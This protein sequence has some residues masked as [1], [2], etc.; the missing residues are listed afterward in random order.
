MAIKNVL[1][2]VTVLTQTGSSS[3]KTQQVANTA[4][5]KIV[6]LHT[7]TDDGAGAFL[8]GLG[9]VNYV[10]KNL[11]VKVVSADRTTESYN[12]DY[13][14]AA[15]F[16][17][18]LG[19]G[20]GNGSSTGIKGGSYG[21]ASVGEEILAA[22][23][24]VAKYRV[25]PAVVQDKSYTFAPEA[26]VIDLCPL[27]SEPIA[28]GS[29]MFEWMG[30]VYQDFE[31][32][33]YRGRTNSDPGIDSGALDYEGGKAMMT[34]YVVGPNPQTINILALWT[35]KGSWK[36]SSSF[37]RTQAAPVKPSSAIINL[38][39]TRG[40]AITVQGD[41]DGNLVGPHS[42]GS[43]DYLSGCGQLLF[44]DLLLDASLTPAEKAEWWY[45]AADVG[46]VE[47]GKIWRPWPIDPT[48]IRINSVSYVYLPIDSA[49]VGLGATTLPPDGRV[50]CHRRGN[51]GVLS[52]FVDMPAATLATGGVVNMG[53][54]RLS[55]VHLIDGNGLPIYTGFT[56]NLNAGT[57]TIDD[58]TGWAQPIVVRHAVQQ[59]FRNA[60]VQINGFIT[61]DSDIAHDFPMGS[62]YSSALVAGDLESNTPVFF[63]QKSWTNVWSDTLIGNKPLANFD[64]SRAPMQLTN[65]ATVT[66]RWV[67]IFTT[68]TQFYVAGEHLGVVYTGDIN[69]DVAPPNPS[70]DN[71]PY[72]LLPKAG[73]G[74]NWAA[75]DC[76]RFNTIGAL[77]SLAA[78]MVVQAGSPEILD[79]N[80]Q[81][82]ARVDT[83]RDPS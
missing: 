42:W 25:A 40:N 72:F 19:N 61:L 7:L 5:G 1:R 71:A 58:A 21:T 11:N 45:S 20:A 36:T 18:T 79:H 73:F 77:Y 30:Q 26:I 23:S 81:I 80:F 6:V 4:D 27:T 12:Q 59:T 74:M 2:P 68:T 46:K 70:A 17:K 83:D 28:P 15:E 64:L 8:G 38:V 47:A 24:V 62:V 22:S 44:G 49:V 53:R 16:Q 3:V 63:T 60:D 82:M 43:F 50:Q 69:S 10:G 37:F 52:N 75:G 56:P 54:E 35:R 65:K 31:G 9:T 41:A 55:S 32:R 29:L 39:D 76:I 33:I 13:E 57:L 51:Y 78:V 67:L 48:T 34:D 66:E 14:D